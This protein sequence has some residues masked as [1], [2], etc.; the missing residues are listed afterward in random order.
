M[1]H[2]ALLHDVEDMECKVLENIEAT[3]DI[4]T[5]AAAAAPK[6]PI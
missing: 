4:Y 2:A 5:T 6:R 3:N 1:P